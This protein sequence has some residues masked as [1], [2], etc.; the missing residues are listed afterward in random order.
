V[1]GYLSRTRELALT[2][3]TGTEDA[4][5]FDFRP[6]E[7]T[8]PD[9]T[10]AP[11]L[12]VDTDHAVDRSVTGWLFMYAGAAVSWAVRGQLSPSLSSTEAELYGLSTGV[13]DL[14]VCIYVLEEMGV[15]FTVPVKVCTDSQGA[16]LIATDAASA[17][18]TRHVHRRWFFVRY[19]VE[20]GRLRVVQVKG[21]D[22][23]ANF[24]TKA[25]GGKPF[26]ENRA[27][28]LG[29]REAYVSV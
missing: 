27:Y 28:A 19:Y 10:G 17:A 21:C 8:K 29:I 18:R 12:P 25:V 22:N 3:R 23:P 14:L 1:L 26:A 4:T 2:Y 13:C 20:D 7:G 16:R 11:H 9:V 24:L 5:T 6:M 15:I